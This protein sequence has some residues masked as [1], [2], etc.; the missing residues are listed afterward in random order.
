MQTKLNAPTPIPDGSISK[1]KLES[2]VQVSLGKADT[3]L[4]VI[5]D[6]S[7]DETKIDP[8]LTAKINA[9]SNLATINPNDVGYDIWP[10]LGQSNTGSGNGIDTTYLDVSD[11]RI[12]QFA[13]TSNSTYYGQ[14][15]K[16][17]DPLMHQ[18][19]MSGVGFAMTFAKNYLGSV[20]PNRR[21]LLVPCGRGSTGFL[22][23]Q[24]YTWDPSDTT[25]PT[26]L[27]NLAI[28]HIRKA[29]EAAGV[30]ARLAGVLWHQ[31]E[32][33]AGDTSAANAYAGHI[34]S[35]IE[36]I[37][38]TFAMPRL[39][40]ILGQMNPDRMAETTSTIPGYS[41]VNSA[42]IDTPRRKQGTAFAY[43]P[44]S[45][46][47]AENEK[48]H[49]N[50]AGQRILGRRYYDAY[51]IAMA[52]FTGSAPST[53]VSVTIKQT[54][55]TSASVSWT[56][57][58]GRVTDYSVE[59]R[60][61]NGIW[62]QLSRS[63]SI[64]NTANLQSLSS[65]ATV[66]ARVYTIN[67]MGTS[68]A[69]TV[70][71]LTLVAVPGQVTGLATG[72]ATVSAQSLTWTSVTG[73][74]S[75]MIEYKLSA[76]SSW[77]QSGTTTTNGYT[78]SGLSSSSA[79][80][81][82][83][84]AI[85]TAG[86]GAPSTIVTGTTLDASAFLTT[87]GIPAYTAYGLRKLGS[88]SGPAITVRRSSDN[89]TQNIGFSGAE[90]DTTS[91][92]NFVGSNTGYVT[93]LYDQSGNSRNLSQSTASNQPTIVDT[94]TLVS[95]NGKPGIRF[96]GGAQ[97]LQGIF[98][99]LYAAGQSSVLGVDTVQSSAVSSA[100]YAEGG[101]DVGKQSR[102]VPRWWSTG[103]AA[104]VNITDDN[105]ATV[106]QVVG[107][108][109]PQNSAL[110]QNTSID[111]GTGITIYTNGT[112]NG[113]EQSYTRTGL[114]TLART[115]IGGIYY[116]TNVTPTAP[117]IGTFCEIITFSTV[118]TGSQRQAGEFNQKSYYTTP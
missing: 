16:A 28:Q 33:D 89:A 37:R 114:M 93:T 19:A 32:G 1:L 73:A 96:A 5:A 70:G 31:G 84:V 4:Q 108:T 86:Q 46:Y 3:A 85:N 105:G 34:D 12:D 113:T 54:G 71:T 95:K 39:P 58:P 103:G 99:G 59:Y 13:N 40:F 63:Q 6:G 111:T 115:A 116:S 69:S 98:A 61:N 47:N 78:V 90:L 62:Q 49:Y 22:P 87:V 23:F 77:I 110:H 17:I 106:K 109:V 8:L 83:V 20:P 36:G 94:G 76:A 117:Y 67:E 27:Y 29:V 9:A 48:I 74:S 18:T 66:D 52:N 65:L 88:Y 68:A 107:S 44:T 38:S 81:Y 2:L 55:P 53:P 15:V 97:S 72:A 30:N 24:G 57:T 92:T 82:R 51:L 14:I 64:D 26:N 7:I 21:V 104:V 80:N 10:I 45:M 118:L 91:L 42:H 35:V 43:G 100:V 41:I 102:Y 25:T 75:Y 101:N 50:A 56:R 79:Y 11:P 60:V 112:M